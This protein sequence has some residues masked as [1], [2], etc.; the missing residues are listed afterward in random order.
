M[1][2]I[3]KACEKAGLAESIALQ[4]LPRPIDK[5]RRHWGTP[6]SQNL[7]AAQVIWF[8][9]WHLRQK[10]QHRRDQHRV[11][12]AFLL[13][14]LTETL[15]AEL[16]NRDLAGAERWCCEHG[17][18]IGNVKN[19]RRMKKDAAFFVSHPI[20]K[21]FDI[22]Q[23]IGVGYDNALRPAR[24][25]TCVDESENRLRL[26]NGFR[27]ELVTNVQ[28]VFVEQKLPRKL[29]CRLRQRGVP[30]QPAGTRICKDSID[31]R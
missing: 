18:K 13:N 29:D 22:C 20:I 25:A 3:F 1:L 10:V 6:I 8:C 27:A 16:W 15:R 26:I 21:V 24:R 12:Y 2:L 28:G 19:W 14:Q 9:F 17:G 23:D 5:F 4:K 7:E 31:F 30:D 11:S